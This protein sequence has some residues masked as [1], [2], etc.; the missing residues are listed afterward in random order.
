MIG[1][2]VVAT[3]V[4]ALAFLGGP[5]WAYEEGFSVII[6]PHQLSHRHLR[7]HHGLL[8]FFYHSGVASIFD[9][10]ERRFGLASRTVMSAIFLFGNALYSGIMLYTAALVLE[11][12][13]AWTSPTPS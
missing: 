8:P 7:R 6:H 13:P 9:Y 2:S 1:L 3:Y 12:S 10:L 11:S 5:A 4:G